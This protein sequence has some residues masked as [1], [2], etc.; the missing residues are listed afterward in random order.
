MKQYTKNARLVAKFADA[1]AME[2]SLNKVLNKDLNAARYEIS[3]AKRILGNM[4]VVF[5]PE[6][7]ESPYTSDRLNIPVHGRAMLPLDVMAVRAGLYTPLNDMQVRVMYRDKSWAYAMSYGAFASVPQDLVVERI[8]K[9]LS[10][11]IAA[12]LTKNN[13][14]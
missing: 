6:I 8:S 4:A 2:R 11:M 1:L 10:I 5:E 3:K 12:E 9:E 14:I 7:L 13:K